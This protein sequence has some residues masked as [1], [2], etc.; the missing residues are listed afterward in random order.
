MTF[1][2]FNLLNGLQLSMLIFLMAIGLTVIFGL[3]DILNLAHAAFYMIGAYFGYVVFQGTGSFWVALVVAPLLPMVLGFMLQYFVLQPLIDRG[4]DAHLDMALLTFGLL[5]FTIGL[6]DLIFF[7]WLGLT[8]MSIDKPAGLGSYINIGTFYPT[9]RLFIVALGLSVALIVWYLL[10][11]TV[12]GAV[13]RAGVDDREMVRAMGVNIYL[14][15]AS[16]FAL[17]CGLAGL[18]GVVAGA[19][20]S[21]DISMGVQILI[22]TLVVV[23]LGGLG[24]VKGCFLGALIVGM[25]ETLAQAYAPALA[26]FATYALLAAMLVFR[27]QGFFGRAP[28]TV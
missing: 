19:E 10:D 18:A 9:Y 5:F 26:L 27:P 13:V 1:F 17:G 6:I 14:V 21:I 7:E 11:R 12:I 8:F 2:L 22:P 25:T 15:F 24:S 4:R 20:L 16:V 28:K 23:V 3:M